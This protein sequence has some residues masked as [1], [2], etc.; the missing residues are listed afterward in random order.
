MSFQQFMIDAQQ[1]LDIFTLNSYDI[2]AEISPVTEINFPTKNS[3]VFA[4]RVFLRCPANL[5]SQQVLRARRDL[6][7][8]DFE[9][10]V[11]QAYASRVGLELQVLSSVVNDIIDVEHLVKIV[12]IVNSSVVD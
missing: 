11:L 4:A 5:W 9:L 10:K 7:V 8:N 3:N 1:L 12:P 6:P 2:L